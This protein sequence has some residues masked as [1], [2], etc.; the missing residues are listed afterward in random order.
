MATFH[1]LLCYYSGSSHH[2]LLTAHSSSKSTTIIPVLDSWH[3]ELSEPLT[4]GSVLGIKTSYLFIGCNS[5]DDSKGLKDCL[6]FPPLLI[7]HSSQ[8]HFIALSFLLECSRNTHG[9]LMPVS[10]ASHLPRPWFR[11]TSSKKSFWLALYLPLLCLEFV[12]R[13]LYPFKC[14]FCLLCLLPSDNPQKKTF[15]GNGFC[16]LCYISVLTTTSGIY[17]GLAKQ[18]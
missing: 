2:D 1:L 5:Q 4:I 12:H 9:T 3:D 8:A 16:F 11:V 10:L 18:W 17:Q 15:C 13:T 14:P 7:Y 6:T